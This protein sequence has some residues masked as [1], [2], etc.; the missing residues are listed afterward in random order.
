MG[1]DCFVQMSSS[2]LS[3]TVFLYKV[4]ALKKNR[5]TPPPPGR[6]HIFLIYIPLVC[7]LLILSLNFSLCKR[8]KNSESGQDLLTWSLTPG[9]RKRAVERRRTM[10]AVEVWPC[11]IPA[12]TQPFYSFFTHLT[13]P[14]VLTLGA[15][16]YILVRKDFITSP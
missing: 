6:G 1:N 4:F 13:I 3:C 11:R 12:Y 14:L 5:P 7:S 10:R 15:S 2:V 8:K 16:Q 9:M